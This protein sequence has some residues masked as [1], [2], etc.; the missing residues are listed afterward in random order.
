MTVSP[1]PPSHKHDD[2]LL[3]GLVKW[4]LDVGKPIISLADVSVSFGTR[5]LNHLNLNILPGMTT[6]VVGRSGS[7]KSSSCG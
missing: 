1:H 2:L 5:D 3:P 4:P 6:V 7:G